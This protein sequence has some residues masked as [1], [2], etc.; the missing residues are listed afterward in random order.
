[1]IE[2]HRELVVWKRAIEM[3]VAIYQLTVGFPR[4]EAYGLTNQI[5]R[6]GVSIASN[7]AEGY[8]RAT[9]G[10]YKHFLAIA[11]GPNLE[12]QTQLVIARELRYASEESI[13]KVESLSAEVG[14]MLTSMLKKL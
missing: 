11:R 7:I 6:A 10:E 13:Q 12:A 3:T 2:S 1:M 8:G 14:K 5:R 4:E 9:K